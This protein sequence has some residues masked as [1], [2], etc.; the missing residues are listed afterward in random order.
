MSTQRMQAD[1]PFYLKMKFWY[2]ILAIAVF[3]AMSLTRT[4]VFT[5]EQV[6]TII[7]GLLGITSGAHALTDIAAIIGQAIEGKR[8]SGQEQPA[9]MAS[10]SMPMASQ[11][12]V[13]V[14]PQPGYIPPGPGIPSPDHRVTPAEIPSNRGGTGGAA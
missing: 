5:N 9:P 7:L 4:V 8:A 10:Q 13:V 11:P 12:T 1:K 2:T 14:G 3:L 6:M